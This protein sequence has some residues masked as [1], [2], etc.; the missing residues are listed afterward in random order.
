MIG[1]LNEIMASPEAPRGDYVLK[2]DFL[3]H[4]VSGSQSSLLRF[5]GSEYRYMFQTLTGSESFEDAF[6]NT[7]ETQADVLGLL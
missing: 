1:T 3:F 4:H 7:K 2:E 6:A 5:F